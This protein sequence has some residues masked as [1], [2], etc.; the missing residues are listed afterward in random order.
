GDFNGDGLPDVAVANEG[1][2]DVAVL[3]NDGIWHSFLVSGFSSPATAGE[4]HTITVTALDTAGNVLTGYTGTVH[5][6]SSDPQAVLPV[7]DYTF[8]A[9]DNGTHS[10]TVRLKTA[11]TQSLTVTDT[12]TTDVFGSQAG[13][14]V[15]PAA[16][17]R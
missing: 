17:S 11:G 2:N 7:T 5:V 13:I 9:G 16:A 10:F 6:S 4:A 14:M 12:T 1:S 8:T 15:S 3:L